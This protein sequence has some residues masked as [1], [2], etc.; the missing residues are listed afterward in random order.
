MAA[1]PGRGAKIA[2]G[3]MKLPNPKQ[4]LKTENPY[5]ELKR[6]AKIL[7]EA[8][9]EVCA[10]RDDLG[11]VTSSISAIEPLLAAHA[12]ADPGCV[13][14]S[15]GHG[16]YAHG[17]LCGLK[18]EEIKGCQ[19]HDPERGL[20]GHTGSLGHGLPL[21]LGLAWASQGKKWAVVVGDAE[22]QCGAVYE[23]LG[24]YNLFEV[25]GILKNKLQIIV[26]FNS[27]GAQQLVS[28]PPPAFKDFVHG[29]GEEGK[30]GYLLSLRMPH[31]TSYAGCLWYTRKDADMPQ[32]RGHETDWHYRPLTELGKEVQPGEKLKRFGELLLRHR[33]KYR[34]PIYMIDC[35]WG[36]GQVAPGIPIENLGIREQ[37]AVSFC[38]GMALAAQKPV[39][40]Y[41][42]GSI[43]VL[44]AL[45]QI[46]L[47]VFRTG[48]PVKFALR[49]P[50]GLGRSHA[51]VS[52][53]MG[54]LEDGRFL[55]EGCSW[56]Y[57]DSKWASKW[58]EEPGPQF[59]VI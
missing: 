18:P 28:L 23:A 29:I 45:E 34:E 14:L 50:Q 4:I 52:E 16:W 26:D 48:A 46:E 21:T 8:V 57:V 24:L 42:I 37:A 41:G 30:E 12:W 32:I 51:E 2:G 49:F 31:G 1:G 36:L 6:Q 13:V 54:F 9:L 59:L 35:G 20:W 39:I 58:L 40:L 33:G 47:D 43:T 38:A 17:L 10:D 5:E 25:C 19:P 11:H 15:K 7:R 3:S 22:G 55:P 53:V 27:W 44:R 56:Y